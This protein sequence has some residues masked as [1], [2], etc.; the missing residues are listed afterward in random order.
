MA[1]S[2]PIFMFIFIPV[3]ALCYFVAPQKFK[4]PILLIF[5]L[6]FYIWG[7]GWLVF[8]L[9]GMIAVNYLLSLINNKA[10]LIIGITFNV[11]VLAAF[12]YYTFITGWQTELII[13]LGLSFI[14][15]TAI[16][17][18]IDVYR[19]EASP[20][21]LNVAF[22]LS[23]FPKISSPIERYNHIVEQMPDR[24]AKIDQI[25]SGIKKFI[26]GL[27]KKVLIANVLGITVD[28]IFQIPIGSL[29]TATAWLGIVCF[30]LQLYF[31]FSG[32]TD[33]A[34][35]IGRIFGFELMENF[36]YPYI[37][38]S[39]REFW[40]RWHITLS[41]W[42]RDYLYIPLGGNKSHTILNLIVVFL[43]CGIWHGAAWTFVVWGLW[44][45]LF[46]VIER[47]VKMP[48]ILGNVYALLVIMIGWVIFRASSL[49]YAFGYIKAMF[50]N[51]GDPVYGISAYTSTLLIVVIAA[52]V[53][54]SLPVVPLVSKLSNRKGYAFVMVSILL[55][56]FA[57]SIMEV[58]S[59]F[60]KPFLYGAF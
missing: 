38:R 56:I 54:G 42:L 36:N 27:S 25:A 34:I 7:A 20:N 48:I 33:M 59:G 28:Q 45:G 16:A 58:A 13:P 15:F 21:L 43:I 53:I 55:G 6:L 31:D 4:I 12:K 50:I 35:G 8:V 9:I 44:H 51:G 57:L 23:F 17:Y 18:L 29:P 10:S 41:K 11:L 39:I 37:S 2:S 46:M 3:L 19:G 5:S 49:E 24:S 32:Y 47:K 60:Y 26:V 1:L 30:T 22:H 52:G 14:V 40:R